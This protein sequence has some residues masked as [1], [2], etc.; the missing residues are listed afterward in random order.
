M[1]TLTVRKAQSRPPLALN[2]SARGRRAVMRPPRHAAPWRAVAGMAPN[3]GGSREGPSVPAILIS[4]GFRPA[5]KWR[6]ARCS[7][8]GRLQ[9][10]PLLGP[11]QHRFHSIQGTAP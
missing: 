1:V 8:A 7:R 5:H 11:P 10:G 4:H 3:R 6:A 9:F 2:S